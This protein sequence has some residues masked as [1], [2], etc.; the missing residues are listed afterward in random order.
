MW[1]AVAVAVDGE[2]LQRLGQ[3]SASAAIPAEAPDF[4]VLHR[5]QCAEESAYRAACPR[6]HGSLGVIYQVMAGQAI[7]AASN[8]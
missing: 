2:V 1:R 4:R 3:K 6:Y 5:L 7:A 8:R